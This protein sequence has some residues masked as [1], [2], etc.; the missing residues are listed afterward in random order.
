MKI[1][2]NSKKNR[3]KAVC[4]RK[5][6][7]RII[8]VIQPTNWSALIQAIVGIITIVVVAVLVLN[9]QGIIKYPFP[10]WGGV[11]INVPAQTT[12]SPALE[13]SCEDYNIPQEFIKGFGATHIGELERACESLGGIWRDEDRD[14]LGCY[15]NPAIGSIDCNTGG[16][17]V[18]GAYCENKLL[19]RWYCDNS[20]AYIGCL[21]KKAVPNEWEAEEPAPEDEPEYTCGWTG[22]N[23]AGTCPATHPLC[24]DI[25]WWDGTM[26]CACLTADEE[27]VHPDWK[28]DGDYYSPHDEQEGD[29]EPEVDGACTDM[30]GFNPFIKSYVIYEGEDYWDMCHGFG[31]AGTTAVDEYV[32]EGGLPVKREVICPNQDCSDGECTSGT[33]TVWQECIKA[34]YYRG[35]CSSAGSSLPDGCAR[36]PSFDTYCG[37]LYP[38]NTAYCC[39]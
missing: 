9:S 19:S 33:T 22:S 38:L 4:R 21:C 13:D 14:E 30:D 3:N 23:C 7:S 8:K 15:W 37:A 17:V 29:G 36:V 35:G 6:S 26:S 16:P 39:S 27:S 5:L 1:N 32:C 2:C 10:S 18:Y 31:G 20:I 24:K 25:E 11:T 28:P 12:Y 34:G